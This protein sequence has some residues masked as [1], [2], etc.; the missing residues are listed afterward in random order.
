MVLVLLRNSP[1]APVT[2]V[3]TAEAA[4]NTLQASLFGIGVVE[5]RRNI[6][7]GPTTAGRVL[8]VL[9]EQGDQVEAGQ[10][11]AEMDPIELAWNG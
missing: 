10:L 3:T 4:R 11:L 1:F 8:R 5:S 2:Q 9:V 7:V 6:L